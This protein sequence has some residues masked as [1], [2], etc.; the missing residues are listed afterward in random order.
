MP[1][2]IL[3]SCFESGNILRPL[4]VPLIF[5]YAAK[6]QKADLK[7]FYTNPTILTNT[8]YNAWKFFQYDALVNYIDETLELEAL[9]FNVQWQY[10]HY[11]VAGKPLEIENLNWK[12]IKE[13]GRIPIATEVIKRLKIMVKDE[14]VIIGVLNGPFTVL[15]KINRGGKN[16]ELLQKIASAELEI[17]QAYSEAGADLVLLFEEGLPTNEETLFEYVKA[18]LP[19]RNVANFFEARLILLPKDADSPQ[20]LDVIQDSV[21]GIILK[22]EQKSLNQVKVSLG[23]ALPNNLFYNA[24]KI[25]RSVQQKLK[26][27]IKPFLLTTEEEVCNIPPQLFKNSINALKTLRLKA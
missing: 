24:E 8:L 4:V 9:C 2:E 12:G 10:E 14:C 13:R 25:T 26:G 16:V 5:S 17:C 20:N 15:K 1:K 18:L 23:L 11:R 19:I 7:S 6:L 22:S 27:G 21:D 3:R